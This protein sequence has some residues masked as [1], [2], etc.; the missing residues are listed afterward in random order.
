MEHNLLI[1]TTSGAGFWLIVTVTFLIAGAVKG[2]SGLGLPT[3]A[4]GLLSQVMPPVQAA[5]LLIVP[6]LVTNVWQ[7]AAGPGLMALGR[8][9]WPL[10]AGICAGTWA[11]GWLLAGHTAGPS[12]SGALGLALM[13]YALIGLA[14][15]KLAVPAR[16]EPVLAPLAG[17]VTGA[18]TALTGVFVI[19]A[20]PYLQGL[21]LDRD[22]LVQAMGLVF[23]CSTLALAVNL[24]CSGQF[25]A[26]AAGSSLLALAPALA[27]MACGQWIRTR[28][29]VQTFRTVFFSALL[30]LGAHLA[31]RVMA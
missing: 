21:R 8:R 27:G 10:L 4:V 25:H 28:L 16:L 29:S 22:A 3:V 31:W 9:L 7:L 26:G 19:P 13:V 5:A 11:A 14:A 17:A 1:N 6:S 23:T 24:L 20:V 15:L 2:I 30:L 12:A 18:L